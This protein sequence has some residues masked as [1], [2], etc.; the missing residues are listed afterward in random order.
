MRLPRILVLIICC[1]AQKLA[2][3][4]EVFDVSKCAACVRHTIECGLKS[5]HMASC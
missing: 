2:G 1:L 4:Q 5:E 3:G